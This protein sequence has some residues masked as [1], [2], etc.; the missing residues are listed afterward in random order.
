MYLQNAG[1]TPCL[2]WAGISAWLSVGIGQFRQRSPRRLLQ[3]NKV[4]RDD[5]FHLTDGPLQL[6]HSADQW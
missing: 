6:R 2:C 1:H 3:F 4:A 5:E